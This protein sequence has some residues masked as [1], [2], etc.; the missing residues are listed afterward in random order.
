MATF[1]ILPDV[2]CKRIVIFGLV[3]AH[4]TRAILKIVLTEKSSWPENMDYK[5]VYMAELYRVKE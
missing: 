1:Y 3:A 5:C 2:H 4:S